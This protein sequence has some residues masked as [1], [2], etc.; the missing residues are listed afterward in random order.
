MVVVDPQWIWVCPGL[1]IIWFLITCFSRCPQSLYHYTSSKFDLVKALSFGV[2][3]YV[4]THCEKGGE[5]T[6]GQGAE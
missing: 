3:I 1:S 4:V 6:A 5:E 2:V